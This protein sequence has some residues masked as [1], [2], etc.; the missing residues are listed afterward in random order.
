MAVRQPDPRPDVPLVPARRR[1]VL[2]SIASLLVGALAILLMSPIV[3]GFTIDTP[4]DALWVAIISGA[5]NALIWP[6]VIRW[7]LPLSVLTLGGATLLLNGVTLW[8]ITNLVPGAHIDS[9]TAAIA[10]TVGS[11]LI[12]TLLAGI[13]SIDD[14]DRFAVHLAK[15][16]R[17]GDE[18]PE[19]ESPGLVFLEIDGLGYEVLRRAL[20]DGHAPNLHRWLDGGHHHL[21]EW[22][23]DL[24]SQT[25]AC[26]AGILHGN[27][28]D[29]PAFRWWEKDR[30]K[31]IVTNHPRDATELERRISNGKG[32]L[33]RGG[34]S[35]A[36]ILSGDAS[37][38]SLTMS[39]VLN[40]RR[41]K[42]GADYYSYFAGSYTV[43]RTALLV[44]ADV[45][46]ERYYAMSQKRLD[47]RPRIK[48]DWR[49]AAMRAFATAIQLDLQIEAVVADV[50]AGRPAIYTTFLAYDEVAHHSGIERADA[51]AVLRR[52]DRR[53]AR[54]A[55]ATVGAPRPYKLVVLSDHGQS[56]GATFL[57]RYGETLEQVVSRLTG[58]AVHPTPD[59]ASGDDEAAGRLGAV[60]TEVAGG[61]GAT[62]TAVRAATKGRTVDGAV[63][64]Q[65]PTD[66][67]EPPDGTPEVIAMA[68]GCL[69]VISFPSLP[70]RVTA[71]QLEERWPQLLQQLADHP[72]VGFAMVAKDDGDTLV[73]GAHGQWILHA[74]GDATLEGEDPLAL[75]P[76]HPLR[77]LRRTSGFA[78]CPDIVVNS[79]YWAETDEVAA[80]EE[81]VGSHGGLGGGQNR[82]FV[83]APHG[84]PW[85]EEPVI[86]AEAIYEILAGWRGLLG[87]DPRDEDIEPTAGAQGTLA[88]PEIDPGLPIG[89]EA[90]AERQQWRDGSP[91]SGT[92]PS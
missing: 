60:L 7:T 84:L 50:R 86:G 8:G 11:T 47:V 6:I 9:L 20:R 19:I 67:P 34:T 75:Y 31:P 42:L 81:L 56:Q 2:R 48:R 5:F 51:L 58:S 29:M 37:Y 35:R 22:E 76:G 21:H 55:R 10:V 87:H 73:L 82:P 92:Q 61:E 69:G 77:H 16:G 43:I 15:L 13:L 78:H 44:I 45:F 52:V 68:S 71:E 27:N 90:Y 32:L 63:Q 36:N 74:N 89:D 33:A 53:I 62:A 39:T 30:G 91:G 79:T 85:P 28:D 49:Y 18:T 1:T 83:L 72:G 88:Q 23:T 65:G 70:G 12:T 14:E 59:A 46:A 54:V 80:F 24:S 4:D 40:V 57:Q 17:R 41:G 26:Q 64:V 3:P 38:S 66:S 25:G